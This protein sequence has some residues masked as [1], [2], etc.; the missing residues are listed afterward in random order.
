MRIQIALCLLASSVAASGAERPALS[1]LADS[2][3][4]SCSSNIPLEMYQSIPLPVKTEKGLRYRLMFYPAGADD[5]RAQQRE[6]NEPTRTAEFAD[7]GGDVAC[8][9][10]P[11]YPRRKFKKGVPRFAPIGL[12][13]SEPA[14]KLS[15]EEYSA[16]EREVYIAVEAAADSFTAGKADAAAAQRFSKGFAVLS[17]PALQGHYRAMA[18]DF[19]AWVDK[20]LKK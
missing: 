9:V 16:L 10:R 8:D 3:R 1:I 4:R 19:F 12:L 17:E 2:A 20:S 15:F 18:P 14:L 6:V 7:K 5:P 11:D 13:M